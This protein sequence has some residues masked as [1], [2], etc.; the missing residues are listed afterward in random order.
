VL[1]GAT[2]LGFEVLKILAQEAQQG[3]A[4]A[5]IGF[6]PCRVPAISL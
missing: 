6:G 1:A 3:L 5:E 2:C 4:G